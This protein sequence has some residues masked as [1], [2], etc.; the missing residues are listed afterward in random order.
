MLNAYATISRTDRPTLK[1]WVNSAPATE[2][3]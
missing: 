3:A 2:S 1:F